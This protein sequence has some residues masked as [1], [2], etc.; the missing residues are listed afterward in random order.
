MK[1]KLQNKWRLPTIDEF[2]EVLYPNMEKIPNLKK[3]SSYW[4][5][6]V[7]TYHTACYFFFY[8]GNAGN[9]V[10]SYAIQVRAVR[11][12]LSNSTN[13]PNTTIIGNLEVHNKNLGP[14]NYFDAVDA[15]EKLNNIKIKL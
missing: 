10:K 6:S 12:I 9:T 15:V 3:N 1:T 13:S 2:K 11:D 7:V 4:S 5:S 8:S 14:M